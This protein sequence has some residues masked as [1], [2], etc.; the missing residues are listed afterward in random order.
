MP[1]THCLPHTSFK[2]VALTFAILTTTSW[3]GSLWVYLLWGSPCLRG[4]DVCILSRLGKFSAII[5]LDEVSVS[6][7][8]SSPSGVPFT[9]MF[10]G[11]R[12]SQRSLK[13][14]CFV[15]L[16]LFSFRCSDRVT[17][18]GLSART[19]TR[20]SVLANVLWSPCNVLSHVNYYSLQVRLVFFL[21]LLFVDVLPS[22]TL[23]SGFF[24]S[25]IR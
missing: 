10:E 9:C 21:Y 14:P 15:L 24:E 5:S 8:L 16:I 11:L 20:S 19:L 3:R 13:L 6:F 1:T 22:S 7:H 18:A 4:L 2:T 17:S 23:K 12:L 25:C